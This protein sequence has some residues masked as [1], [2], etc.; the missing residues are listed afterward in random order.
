[1]EE[2]T[3]KGQ[4]IGQ[5]PKRDVLTGNEQFPFQ[6][7]RE[8]G[9]IT[10]NALKSF[11]SSGK[12]GYMSYITEYNVS[13]HHPSSGIDGSNRYTLEDA[14]VQVPE[15]IRIAGLKVSF[16]N[17][18]GLV[19]T[20]EFA[21]GVFENIENWKSNEDKLTDIRDE[22]ISKI[23]EVESD[24]ISN[25]SSSRV[26][27]EMLSESTKQFIN[28]SGGG[29][30]NNLADDEDLVSVDKGENLS[31]L[32]FADR[33]YNPGIYVGMG[34]KIL[35]RN[36]IDGKNILTQE[37]VNQPHTIYMIQYDYDL[38]GATIRIP[39]G[40][41]FDFQG[42]SLS[43]GFIAG[44]NTAIISVDRK[45]FSN[46][47]FLNSLFSN[48]FKV[49]WFGA[50]VSD[51]IDSSFAFNEAL[52]NVSNV[53]A[54]GEIYYLEYPIVINSDYKTLKC[55][56]RLLC[57]YGINGIESN[58]KYLNIQ[59]NQLISDYSPDNLYGDTLGSGIKINNNFNS[60]ISID[61]IT[62]FKYGIHL[63]PR[64]IEGGE[65]VSGIQ[66]VKFNFSQ[67][68]AYTCI[69]MDVDVVTDTPG[70]LWI[71][72]S[73]FNGGRLKG[74]NGISFIGYEE[75]VSEINGHV[76]NSIG[77]EKIYN[78]IALKKCVNS[79]FLNLRMSEDIYG[80]YYLNLEN[81]SRLY[82]DI[83]SNSIGD[84]VRIIN[85]PF[86]T[87]NDDSIVLPLTGV[88][89][90]SFR[91]A[92]LDDDCKYI[93]NKINS[94]TI[95]SD[96]I[97][98]DNN[99]YI[100][101]SDL[102]TKIDDVNYSSIHKKI[103]ILNGET[104][105]NIGHVRG[106]DRVPYC[107]F[108]YNPN[109]FN[110]SILSDG[111]VIYRSSKSMDYIYLY[112]DKTGYKACSSVIGNKI[113][114]TQLKYYKLIDSSKLNSY[115]KFNLSV[116]RIAFS[117]NIFN[118]YD[119]SILY[120]TSGEESFINISSPKVADYISFHKD[121]SNNLYIKS[122]YNSVISS[123]FFDIKEVDIDEGKLSAVPV[124]N[125]LKGVDRPGNV[126]TGYLYFDDNLGKPIWWNGS[127]WVDASG[128]TV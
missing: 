115:N 92:T 28:A 81:C 34:Y 21:G 98:V 22:A 96:D 11:I 54:N 6:E 127:S 99:T 119:Y 42:G 82:F 68:T 24:V 108:I 41:V 37:M 106:L 118:T 32:K 124:S 18:S 120:S 55:K 52:A 39:E 107:L 88:R 97:V 51:N 71:T 66:Y 15:T 90:S 104:T 3:E 35:R 93:I 36:I 103:H 38:N 76:F 61:F 4:Q 126:E 25:F 20:W 86:I 49:E 8:N 7:D 73:Q 31:V 64:I 128:T 60:V 59:I 14:I 77:F 125:L 47:K 110:Y 111:R 113:R 112:I 58:A 43:N 75:S 63:C 1:M 56:G 69:L 53:E 50:I 121:E 105:I 27:P 2:K 102:V 74:Y 26:T 109:N 48:A 116:N 19:E 65:R 23:K 10:P 78:P 57:K 67:I 101:P 100:T 84:K 33:A 44:N 87:V 13:I 95:F 122:V 70:S 123:D 17:N 29:T 40:C 9:S 5:L 79:K 89:N 72:E 114:L 46:I 85:S 45:I 83:K 80:E 30:I 94:H 62:N 12:G 91:Y 117:K 16:L